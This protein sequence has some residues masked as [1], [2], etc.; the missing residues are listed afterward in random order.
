MKKKTEKIWRGKQEEENDID[1]NRKAKTKKKS[2][3]GVI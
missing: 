3:P 2:F 1:F